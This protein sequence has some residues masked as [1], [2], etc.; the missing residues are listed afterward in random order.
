MLLEAKNIV[1]EFYNVRALDNVNFELKSGE[2]HALL[3]E[4]GAGKSTM[5]KIFSGVH[6]K[7]SG[8]IYYKGTEV[9]FH[10]P[11]EALDLGISTIYQ[12]LNLC[13]HLSI[14]HN[15]FLNREFVSNGIIN[16]KMQ[17]EKTREI[18]KWLDLDLDPYTLVKDISIAKRQMVEIAKAISMDSSVLIMDE[19]TSS[20]SDK[21]IDSLFRVMNSLKKRGYG[22]IYISHRLEELHKI[23]DRVTIFRD[24]QYITTR[25]INECSLDEIITHMAGRDIKDKYPLITCDC[26]KTRIEVTNLTKEGLFKDISFNIR[27]GEILG[28]SGLI[29][30]GRTELAKGIFGVYGELTGEIKIDGNILKIKSIMDA[31]NS[32]IAYIPEDRKLEGLAVRMSVWENLVLPSSIEL[33]NNYLG[34]L[35]YKNIHTTTNEFIQKLKIKTTNQYQKIQ[36]LSGGNQ[37]KVV[38]AKWLVKKPKLIIF[39]EPTRGIDVNSKVSIYQLIQELKADGVMIIIISSELQEIFGVADRVL[40]M[41]NGRMTGIVDVKNTTQEDILK[42]ATQYE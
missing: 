28:I 27:E 13:L 16:T 12:E 31:I 37:Q 41:C 21:E 3:G 24:G 35:D 10:S 33:S 36:D 39:D 30:A 17:E 32:G 25:N 40:V 34:W 8:K 6:Q 20:L 29:G 4:N 2:I 42:L 38:I 9:L 19:P 26:G 5:M 11:K 22:I 18:L 1:K 7:D 23:A 14:M 15:I